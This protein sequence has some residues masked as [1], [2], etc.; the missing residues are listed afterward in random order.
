MGSCVGLILTM[1]IATGLTWLFWAT[2]KAKHVIRHRKDKRAG[3]M[4]TTGHSTNHLTTYTSTRD[5][6]LEMSTPNPIQG[7]SRHTSYRT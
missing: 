2:L 7:K 4:G 1:Y 6:G 3:K 5:F